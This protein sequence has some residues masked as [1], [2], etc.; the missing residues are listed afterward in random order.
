MGILFVT[1]VN[2]LST[3]GV[4]VDSNNKLMYMVDGSCLV[5]GRIPLK[6]GIGGSLMIFG[7][8]VKQRKINFVKI[9]SLI[10]NQIS[11]PDTHRGALERCE[12]LCVETPCRVIN[13]PQRILQTS[14]DRIAKLLQG[15]PGVI[16]PRTVRFQP[17]SPEQ[18]FEYAA[19]EKID[20]P[21]IVRLAGDHG[22]KSMVLVESPEDHA[23]LHVFPFDGRGFYLT[24][25]VDYKDE[26]GL[27]HKQRIAV[28]DGEPVLRHSLFSDQWIVHGRSRPFMMNRETWAEYDA[29][30]H[31]L[32]TV[33]IPKLLPAIRE[34]SNRLK[35]EYFGIDCYMRP[36]GEMLNFEANANMNI[37]FNAHPEMNDRIKLLQQKILTMLA[38]H[39]G[40]VVV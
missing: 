24:E 13:H 30:M 7:K 3:M 23:A 37:L 9:P 29:R 19:G 15:I 6:K 18:V 35:L 36:D 25:Y 28:I 38:R 10:F 20:F 12:E 2:D 17:D 11:D 22:G 26:E 1:G 14:R 34:I 5:H 21:F 27:Y 8:R 40:E 39:S 4:R 32:E 31:Q 33:A 16:M